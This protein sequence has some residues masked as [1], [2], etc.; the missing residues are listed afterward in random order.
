MG[1]VSSRP[2]EGAALVLRDQIRR[3]YACSCVL[4]RRMLIVP[5]LVSIASLT[6]TNNRRK[7]LLH[8][9]PNAYPASRILVRR[10]GNDEALMTFIQVGCGIPQEVLQ[11]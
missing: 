4:E 7:V 2:E 5:H 10:E 3:E 6:V 1:N 8:A 9:V 11:D